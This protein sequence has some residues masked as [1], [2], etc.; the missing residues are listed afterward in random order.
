V[1]VHDVDG[2]VSATRELVADPARRARLA[3]GARARAEE[4]GRPAFARRLHALVDELVARPGG[5][6]A[7]DAS[8]PGRS[9]PA[10]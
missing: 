1:L 5:R 9:G 7:G 8:G 4:F 10:R 6:P 3:D 2:F